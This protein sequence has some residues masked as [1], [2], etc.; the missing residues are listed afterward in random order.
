MYKKNLSLILLSV[1]SFIGF[2]DSIYLTLIG[3]SFHLFEQMCSNNVCQEFS[4]KIFNIHVSV[5]GI[6][7]YFI[8]FILSLFLFKNKVFIKFVFFI[9]MVGLFFSLY[10]LYY[11]IFIINGICMFCL[12]SFF[13]TLIFFIISL[14][15]L[16]KNYLIIK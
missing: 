6:L 16:I 12:L 9:S 1:L 14:Y 8:L 3:P 13:V 15:I 7:Y 11:Q 10:F 5:Y 4:M 2:C